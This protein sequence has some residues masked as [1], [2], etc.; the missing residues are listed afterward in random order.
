MIVLSPGEFIY[1]FGQ[2]HR[3]KEI[4]HSGR[5]SSPYQRR[6]GKK[7][8]NYHRKDGQFAVCFKK[9]NFDAANFVGGPRYNFP[10]MAFK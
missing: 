9:S 6:I 7:G 4:I 5:K 3:S 1:P 2:A 8:R 10:G